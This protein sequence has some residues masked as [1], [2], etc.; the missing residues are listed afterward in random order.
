MRKV[1]RLAL[2]YKGRGLNMEEVAL[3]K[4]SKHKS[5]EENAGLSP[6]TQGGLLVTLAPFSP[7]RPSGPGVPAGP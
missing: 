3:G 4:A 5:G 6:S 7:C 1:E 2:R